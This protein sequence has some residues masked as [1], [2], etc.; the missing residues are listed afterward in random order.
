MNAAGLFVQSNPCMLVKDFAPKVQSLNYT[1]KSRQ[2]RPI[3]CGEAVER[4][5]FKILAANA[6]LE[7]PSFQAGQEDSSHLQSSDEGITSGPRLGSKAIL[8]SGEGGPR[9]VGSTCTLSV[10]PGAEALPELPRGF[11]GGKDLR[12]EVLPGPDLVLP[13]GSQSKKHLR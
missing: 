10:K 2:T 11:T 4:T 1:T 3:Q 13:F 7:S 12:Q 8:S 5:G 6:E 9:G